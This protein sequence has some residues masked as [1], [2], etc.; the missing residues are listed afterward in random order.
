MNAD[1]VPKGSV[2]T[3]RRVWSRRFLGQGVASQ[4]VLLLLA[5][6]AGEGVVSPAHGAKQARKSANDDLVREAESLLRDPVAKRPHKQRKKTPNS[7]AP[8]ATEGAPANAQGKLLSSRPDPVT[9]SENSATNA[10]PLPALPINRVAPVG[11]TS[12]AASSSNTNP[13]AA[14]AVSPQPATLPLPATTT[15]APAQL[16]SPLTMTTPI[17][18]AG[19]PLPS[20]DLNTPVSPPLDAGE[21]VDQVPAAAQPVVQSPPAQLPLPESVSATESARSTS[22]AKPSSRLRVSSR[23]ERV[24]SGKNYPMQGVPQSPLAKIGI[25]AAAV[26]AV[27]TVLTASVIAFWPFLLKTLTMLLK[28]VI[29][30]RLKVRAKKDKKIDTSQR[31]FVVFG[32][33]L[34]PLELGAVLV[35]AV[36]Y[37]LAICY[38][39]KGWKLDSPFLLGQE[40]IVLAIYYLRSFIRLAFE[41]FF[42][43]ATQF[44]FWLVG[45]LLC[46]FSAFLGSPLATVGYELESAKSPQ[47][48]EQAAR[49]KVAL[50][51]ATLCLAVGFFATNLLFP[52]KLLQS[53]RLITSGMALAEV[54]PITPMPGL[55]IYQWRK[56]VWALLF[57]LVVPTYFLI[58]FFL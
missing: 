47:A 48:A 33:R 39:L 52:H 31:Q 19:L 55:K 50:L 6:A 7:T 9:A 54:L 32:F 37:G 5:L 16:G 27:A 40:A 25:P 44:R 28:A 45:G 18:D 17:S 53:G 34:R 15:A 22:T 3:H 49:L 56:G 57:A 35:G 43:L 21:S 8:A 46:L 51:V 13:L 11:P 29:T 26:P 24:S 23:S 30:G 4:V 10:S 42:G 38:T 14:P 1:S 41:R 2:S 58:N 20:P 36:V 12:P